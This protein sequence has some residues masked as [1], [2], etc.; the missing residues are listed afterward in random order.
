VAS[1][2]VLDSYLNEAN[3]EALIKDAIELI[4]PYFLRNILSPRLEAEARKVFDGFKAEATA[5]EVLH[6]YTLNVQNP[7]IRTSKVT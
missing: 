2:R 4:K 5:N 1:L 6:F 7:E 3:S